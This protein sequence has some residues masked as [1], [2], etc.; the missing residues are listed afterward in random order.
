MKRWMAAEIRRRSGTPKMRRERL[1]ELHQLLCRDL[2]LESR[3]AFRIDGSELLLTLEMLI[4]ASWMAGDNCFKC[5]PGGWYA[6]DSIIAETPLQ[7]KLVSLRL[8]F[9]FVQFLL[10]SPEQEE[11]EGDHAAQ[12]VETGSPSASS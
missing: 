6:G 1:E 7:V 4:V 10:R 3:V 8:V 2:D 11:P 9:K 5:I 12:T